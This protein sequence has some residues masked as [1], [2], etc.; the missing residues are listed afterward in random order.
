MAKFF[1]RLHFSANDTI[2]FEQKQNQSVAV[3]D[4]SKFDNLLQ[5]Y[6]DFL[7][8]LLEDFFID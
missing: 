1:D 5:E 2:D 3:F 8:N 7:S 6:Q 4:N